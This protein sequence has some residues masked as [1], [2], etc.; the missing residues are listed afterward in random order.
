MR[1]LVFDLETNGLH[2]RKDLKVHCGVVQNVDTD[3]VIRFGPGSLDTLVDYL[4]TADR[5]VGHNISGF[6]I[7]VLE[8][9]LG[10]KLKPG[11]E[12]YDTFLA[13][14]MI[15]ASN[16]LGHSIKIQRGRVRAAVMD[17]RDR[18]EIAEEVFPNKLLNRHSLESWGYRLEKRK[19]THLKKA[20][21]GADE[22]WSIE[23]EDYCARDVA[24]TATLY[25]HLLKQPA[26]HGWGVCSTSSVLTESMFG[27]IIG[28]Q[29]RGGAGFNVEAAG[30]L[31]GVLEE[32]R[33]ILF[34]KLQGI[35]PPWQVADWKQFTPKI[36]RLMPPSKNWPHAVQYTKGVPL[37]RY[38]MVTFKPGSGQHI[39]NRL[40]ELYG[41]K[42]TSFTDDGQPCTD[43]K[44][45]KPLDY[46][47]IPELC[48]YQIVAKRIGQL[49]TG[50]KAWLKFVTPEG[51][52]H[53][54]VKVSGTR[55][56]RCS[57][58][59][60]NLGN[61]P[62][63]GSPYGEECRGLFHPPTPGRVFVG[64]DA[65]GIELRM[66]ASRMAFYDDGAFWL[67][68]SEGDPHTDWMK[69]TGI[70]IRNNQKTWTYATLYGAGDE[71]LGTI[72]IVDWR[73]AL[74]KGITVK[75]VPKGAGGSGD[76]EKEL[77]KASRAGLLSNLPALDFL[78]KACKKAQKNGWL[79]GIDGAVIQC[80]TEH[81]AL[82]DLLQHDAVRIM[83][84]AKCLMAEWLVEQDL[85][86]RDCEFVLDIHDEWQIESDPT[87]AENIGKVGCMMIKQA[88]EELGCRVP[89]DGEFKI[90]KNWRETH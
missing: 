26:K 12:L 79:R 63:V 44:T 72:I 10:F 65:S 31:F 29:E 7:P 37:Q 60:P 85:L 39:A 58:T 33:G 18:A 51:K 53:G 73:Q 23:L 34:D 81:G 3:A 32:R 48:E 75:P 42:P 35:F 86:G 52:I 24:L 62:K 88:G 56:L 47:G 25:Q 83:K 43:E 16:M 8:R 13:S 76:I 15:Y 40:M 17:K 6:D 69:S 50:K 41:W 59:D 80:K 22:E 71:K 27:Y 38:K 67:V 2:K 78:L 11:V 70:Y 54:R 82:N 87:Y 20:P 21:G 1:T 90:G 19:G 57:H 28:R 14:R 5:L 4:G 89:L 46:E 55:T 84:H 49:A 61:V 68:L 66:L 64:I 45:L 30:Q 74:E 9:C 77:G 36:T